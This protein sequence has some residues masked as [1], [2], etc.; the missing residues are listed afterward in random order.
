MYKKRLGLSYKVFLQMA[1]DSPIYSFFIFHIKISLVSIL[2][3]DARFYFEITTVGSR[4][5]YSCSLTNI[6]LGEVKVNL[7]DFDSKS[8]KSFSNFFLS[9]FRE[10]HLANFLNFI[11]D[12]KKLCEKHFISLLKNSTVV[13]PPTFSLTGNSDHLKVGEL[14]EV[15]WSAV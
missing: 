1:S 2:P 10:K 14:S 8:R 4:K 12:I 9:S 6:V 3:G 15:I 5:L 11:Q 7:A 13:P